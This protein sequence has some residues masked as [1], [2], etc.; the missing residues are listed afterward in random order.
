MDG[1]AA[2]GGWYGASFVPTTWLADLSM[3]WGTRPLSTTCN[4]GL[5]LANKPTVNDTGN[6]TG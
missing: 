4:L 3:S 1:V 5:E 6:L 2:V